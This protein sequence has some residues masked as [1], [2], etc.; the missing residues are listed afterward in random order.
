MAEKEG[1][2]EIEK[3]MGRE[4]ERER[5]GGREGEREEGERE[6]H[7]LLQASCLLPGAALAQIYCK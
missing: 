2:R 4:R 7:H 3:E 6:A 5:E 1:A